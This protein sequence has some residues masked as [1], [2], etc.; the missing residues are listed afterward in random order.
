VPMNNVRGIR[1]GQD[2]LSFTVPA[3]AQIRSCDI[4]DWG[5]AM[6]INTGFLLGIGA[7]VAA[8]SGQGLTA[9]ALEVR[10]MGQTD[11]EIREAKHI[12]VK[13]KRAALSDGGNRVHK[14]SQ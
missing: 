8:H 6:D 2:L 14:E 12:A 7:I 1:S 10:V 11:E 13:V 5:D 4:E 3:N 9:G